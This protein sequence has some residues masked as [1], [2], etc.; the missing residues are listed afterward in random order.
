MVIPTSHAALAPITPTSNHTAPCAEKVTTMRLTKYHKQAIVRS[1]KNDIPDV[2][3]EALKGRI[4]AAFVAAMSPAVLHVYNTIPDALKT[5]R[6]YRYG[7]SVNY[8]DFIVG[9][10]KTDE[11]F[12]P[13][14]TE[15]EERNNAVEKFRLALG[16]ITTRKQFVTTFPEFEKYAPMEP[17]KPSAYPLAINGVVADLTK[18]GW[19][20]QQAQFQQAA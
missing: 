2:D 19:P 20:K 17:G 7:C 8:H 13:F 3:A 11:I 16:G 10:T 1:V 14:I 15:E 6:I 4:Q 12:A 18:L 5:D 9:D